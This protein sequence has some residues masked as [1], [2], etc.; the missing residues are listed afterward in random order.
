MFAEV[1]KCEEEVVMLRL[2]GWCPTRMR[3]SL[4]QLVSFELVVFDTQF[5]WHGGGSSLYGAQL[6]R[7]EL[8][9]GGL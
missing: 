4:P 6:R 2:G 5:L 1:E 7:A 9:A 8:A 3:S